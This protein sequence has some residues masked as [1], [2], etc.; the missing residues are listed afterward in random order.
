[1]ERTIDNVQSPV[2]TIDFRLMLRIARF[3]WWV[4]VYCVIAGVVAAYWASARAPLTYRA[5][6][7]LLI[8]ESSYSPSQAVTSQDVI[9]SNR[10]N[11]YL[12]LFHRDLVIAY[13]SEHEG[14]SEHELENMLG[15]ISGERINRSQLYEVVVTALDPAIAFDV[16]NR[17]PDVLNGQINTLQEGRFAESRASLQAQMDLLT[18]Q[19]AASELELNTARSSEDRSAAQS[20]L[21]QYQNTFS[22]LL[23]SFEQLRLL[24]LQTLDQI[25]VMR[26]PSFPES[27]ESRNIMLNVVLGA[28][29]GLTLGALI[30]AMIEY[31][32][33]RV[34][35]PD[36]LKQTL[37]S[38]FLGA[39]GRLPIADEG[40]KH[41]LPDE[42][43]VARLPRHPISEAYRAI[44]TNIRFANVDGTVNTFLV[45]SPNP[46]DGKSTTTA[47]LAISMAQMELSVLLIDADMRKPTQHK[48]F[49]VRNT[50]GLSNALFDEAQNYRNYIHKT[51][52]P[53]LT[54]MPSGVLPP[55][56]AE[57]LSSQRLR[58]LLT[59]LQ[60]E[61]DLIIFDTPPLLAVT[62]AAILG[63]VIG[64]SVL[65]INAKRTKQTA[66]QQAAGSLRNVNGR[67]LGVV[68]ND[69]QENSR[70][71]YYYQDF[72]YTYDYEP[73]T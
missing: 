73:A 46:G 60:G 1:M 63:S 29:I 41:P 39:I 9:S 17:L 16:A 48:L 35:S 10:A 66:L 67:L 64:N 31:M 15:V 55:N 7:L 47:N 13:L 28:L 12:A 23:Q 62:D 14:L 49:R 59:H 72:Y 5:S 6:T 61:F 56:P 20:N 57:L 2:S 69:L 40:K 24:E 52:L 19:I 38:N 26:S 42:L 37:N 11:T 30:V 25:T 51:G 27:A 34:Q 65:V 54:L 36:Q 4:F 3:W 71:Y 43:I 53:N 68:M 44:R 18:D 58:L 8:E 22:S 45:T 50:T 33:D 32:D 70:S 21:V